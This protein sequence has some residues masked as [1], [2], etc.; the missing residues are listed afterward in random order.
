[1]HSYNFKI[2]HLFA[3]IFFLIH[4][5]VFISIILGDK[6]TII[7]T[8]ALEQYIKDILIYKEYADYFLY[9]HY[10]ISNIRNMKR[11]V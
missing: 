6:F 3:W 8:S 9:L 1:M 5:F 7:I 2:I 11:F 4:P 10:F